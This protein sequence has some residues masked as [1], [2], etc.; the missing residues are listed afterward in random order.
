MKKIEIIFAVLFMAVMV[1]CSS[2]FEPKMITSTS[3]EFTSG[4][5]A[6]YVE[7]V[8]QPSELSYAEKDETQYIRLKVTLKMVK[9]GIKDVDARDINFVGLLSVA[10]IGLVDENGTDVQ[11]L[12][13]KDDDMLKLKKLLTGD[14]GDTAEI[15]FEGQFNNHKNAPK[16][17]EDA[18]K[19]TPGLTGDII[20]GDSTSSSSDDSSESNVETLE[21]EVESTDADYD[22]LLDTYEEYCDEYIRLVKKNAGGDIS[23]MSEYQDFMVKVQE[24]EEKFGNGVSNLNPEQ[25]KRFNKIHAKVINAAQSMDN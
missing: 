22:A 18:A 6:K 25:L 20:Y 13:V 14:S 2:G 7:I 19:F 12:N 10:V 21:T 8:D 15:I 3:T 9:D 11:E 16:W 24:L 5:L 4:E 1:S 23:T 17:F